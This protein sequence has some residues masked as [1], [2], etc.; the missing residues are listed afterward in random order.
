MA[1]IEDTEPVTYTVTLGARTEQNPCTAE[2]AAIAMAMRCLPPYVQ[3]RQITVF[4]S[5]QAALLSVSQ[6]QHQ[7]G[8]TSIRR[9][10]DAVTVCILK[11]SSLRARSALTVSQWDDGFTPSRGVQ[12]EYLLTRAAQCARVRSET[13]MNPNS[14]TV[15]KRVAGHVSRLR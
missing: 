2:L 12:C 14:Q 9:I 3:G 6:P 11:E 15:T 1:I 5:N 7:S 10:Y 4:T 8:Q 13:K